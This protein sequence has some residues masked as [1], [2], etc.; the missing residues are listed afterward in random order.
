MARRNTDLAHFGGSK[1]HRGSTRE[2]FG[3]G[4]DDVNV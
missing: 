1:H 2:N 4:A 3:F